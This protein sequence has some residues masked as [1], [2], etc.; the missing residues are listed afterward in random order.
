MRELWAGERVTFDGDYY[1]TVD[2][3]IYGAPTA[4]PDLGGGRRA[5]DGEVAGRVGDGFI[6]TRGKGMDLYTDKLMPAVARSPRG[7]SA[8]D[9]TG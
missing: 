6:C 3:T 2:A 7:R 9:F 4:G 5:A 8:R 1:R